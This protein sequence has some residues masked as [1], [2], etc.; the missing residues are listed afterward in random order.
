M[1]NQ[2]KL[3]YTR[4]QSCICPEAS[5]NFWPLFLNANEV[6]SAAPAGAAGEIFFKMSDLLKI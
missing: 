4:V 3:K 2:G 6:A 5:E 1:H